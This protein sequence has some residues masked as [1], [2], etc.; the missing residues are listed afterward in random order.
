[1][2]HELHSVG[3][4]IDTETLITYPMLLKGG[5]DTYEGTQVHIDDC[6]VDFFENLSDEDFGTIDYLINQRNINEQR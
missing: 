3:C 5:Y 2:I 1:M 4:V 6:C